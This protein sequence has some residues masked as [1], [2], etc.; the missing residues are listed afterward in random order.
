MSQE[1][2]EKLIRKYI[3]AYNRF[4][5]EG[6]LSMLD[7][8]ISFQNIS[9]DEVTAF[10]N[11]KEEFQALAEKSKEIFSERKQTI[12]SI[13][14]SGE[15]VTIGISYQGVLAIDLSEDLM[16]GDT[17]YVEGCSRFRFK[18]SKIISIEDIS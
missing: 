1:L 8:E 5:I 11:G 7:E 16:E 10:A 17:L 14:F 15:E 3:E 6:M 9:D 2:R 18:E 12:K 13:E 4:D